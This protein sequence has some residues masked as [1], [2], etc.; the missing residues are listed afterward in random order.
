MI[1][2]CVMISCSKNSRVVVSKQDYIFVINT[3][4]SSSTI[5]INPKDTFD[6]TLDSDNWV[7]VT[8][9]GGVMPLNNFILSSD[10]LTGL[11]YVGYSGDVLDMK[12]D[13]SFV[14]VSNSNEVCSNYGKPSNKRSRYNCIDLDL[15]MYSPR[16]SKT[17][18]RINFDFWGNENKSIQ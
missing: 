6:V 2:G 14:F 10:S 15:S 4:R 8:L 7:E 1:I 13:T 16:K 3:H 18:K 12:L 17:I 9:R 5:F 11:I